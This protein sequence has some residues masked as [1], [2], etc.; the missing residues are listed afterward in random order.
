MGRTSAA[1]SAALTAAMLPVF[2]VG[3]LGDHLRRDLGIGETGLG[4]IVTALFLVA[5]VAAPVAGRLAERTG[6]APPL[7]AGVLGAAGLAAVTA[8]AVGPWHLGIP[9][10]AVGVS[11]ALVDTGA[12]RAF[13]DQIADDRLGTAFGIKEASVPT[14]SLLA[15][16]A[17]PTLAAGVGWRSAFVAAAG[18]AVATVVVVPRNPPVAGRVSPAGPGDDPQRA[19]PATGAI[20][21]FA[22]GIGLGA[23]AATA[24]AT[25]MVPAML[26]RGLAAT[27]AGLTLSAAS[28]ASIVARLLLGRWADRPGALPGRAI[29]VMCLVGAG[30]GA[31]LATPLTGASATAAAMALLGAGWGWTGLAFLAAVRAN[32]AAPGAAAGTVLSGLG[33]GGALGPLAYGALAGRLGYATAWVAVALAFLAAAIASAAARRRLVIP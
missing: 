1:A 7:R 17:V 16:L 3:A 21:V 6:P 15:G 24:A 12:A 9:L 25:F 31:L 27:T 2:L 32:P 18:I 5:A 4:A 19:G 23:G 11:I 33:A 14:A 20:L 22:A 28:I 30:A 10:A 8:A 13:A 26:D 29:A